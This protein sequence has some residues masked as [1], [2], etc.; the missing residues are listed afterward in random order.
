MRIVVSGASG[1]MGS[2]LAPALRARGHEVI[3][4]VRRTVA[5]SEHAI[6]WDP[7]NGVLDGS[8][9]EGADA[10]VHLAGESLQALRWTAAKKRR[11]R[12]SRVQGTAL[13][14]R[15][16]A[17]LERRPEVLI[18][19]SATGF[20]GS[21]G[22][23]EL[24]E[25][26]AAGSGFLASVAQAWE[27]A[28]EPAREAGIRVVHTRAAPVIAST[29]PL[30]RRQLPIFRLGLGGWFGDGRQYW[31]WVHLADLVGAVLH[32]LARDDIDGPVNVVAPQAVT[33]AEFAR[34]LGRIIRRPVMLPVVSPLARLM[35]GEVANEMLLT[36]Q[37]VVPA[38]LQATEFN[39]EYPNLE[40]ALRAA[41]A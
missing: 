11:I 36:S 10:V 34:T 27:A 4:L 24:R 29:A 17:A 15:T 35:F 3:P 1:F 31:P 16:V 30:V 6:R 40:E 7:A 20:Y 19:G 8:A 5:A 2:A 14:A 9:L 13:L 33:N 41:L 18:V 32:V 37:R 12:E 23:S 39:F 38:R 22:D 25:D 26:S 21:R 28:A